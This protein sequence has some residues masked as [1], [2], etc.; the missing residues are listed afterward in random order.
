MFQCPENRFCGNPSDFDL[1]ENY[2]K[3]EAKIQNLDY[4]IPNFDNIGTA[5]LTVFQCI[6][7]EG[8][9]YINYRYMDATSPIPT[10]LFFCL[11]II[12]GSFFLINLTLAVI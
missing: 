4:N 9:I 1:Y 8:W 6:T 12:F 3:E 10:V 2:L 5:M 7:L 11:L